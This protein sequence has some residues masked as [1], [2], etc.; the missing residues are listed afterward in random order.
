MSDDRIEGTTKKV[1]GHVQDAVG[2]LTGSDKTQAKGKLNEA[3]GSIQDTVG[4]VKDQAADALAQS[5][6]KAQQATESLQEWMKDQP[7]L[8]A[9][10]LVGG[11]VV[12][13][14]LL[15][16]RKVVYVRK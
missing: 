1:V 5:K 10:V 11:G 2:G 4:K 8:A 6:D 13:G 9:G 12:L 15:R 16:G 14:L 7:L 3:S